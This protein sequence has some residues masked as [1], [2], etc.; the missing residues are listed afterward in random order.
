LS[1]QPVIGKISLFP[2]VGFGREWATAAPGQELPLTDQIVID[3][4]QRLS[5]FAKVTNSGTDD[6]S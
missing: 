1:P 2:K 4:E 3:F 6:W 5:V